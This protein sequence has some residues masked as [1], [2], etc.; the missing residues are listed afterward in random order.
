MLRWIIGLSLRLQFLVIV[1]AAVLIL[2]GIS[3]LREMPVDVYPEF[4]PP[5][6]E[7]QTEALG[8]SAVEMEALIT[9]PLEADLLNGVAWLDQ[10]YSESVAGLSSILLVFEPGTDPIKARQMVQERLTQTFALPNVSSPPTMLQPLSTTSRVMIVGLSSDE[11]SLLEMGVLARWN[12]KP[13]LTGVP[14]VANV[15]IWGHRDR[16]LQVLVDPQHL[17]ESGVSVQQVIETTGEALW[18]SPLSYLESSSPGTA[19]WIDTPNQRLSIRHELPISSAEELARVP[20][21]GTAWRLED[22]ATVVEDHQPLIGDAALGAEPGLLLVIE[23]FPGANTLEV[24]R[25]VEEA[26]DAMRP[27]LAGLEIDSTVFRSANY[28]EQAA[29]NLSVGLIA[30]MVLVVLVLFAFFYNW[31]TALISVVAVILP[32]IAAALVLYLRDAT[33]NMMILAG[34]VIALGVV[35][36]NA[37]VDVDNIVRRLRQHREREDDGTTASVVGEAAL[38]IRGPLMFALLIML[39]AIAPLFFLPGLGGS[40]LRPLAVS[41]VLALLT[42]LAVALLVTPALCLLFLRG[43]PLESR[44]SPIV[45]RLQDGYQRLL[46]RV[47]GIPR[48]AFILPVVFIG[49]ALATLPFLN[50]SLVP[51]FQQHDL[52]IE[53]EAASGTSRAEM[54]RV[55][56]RA[57]E[58]LRA[59]PG[60]RNVG[61]HVG[62]AITGD[63]VVGINSGQMW[64]SIDSS[65]DYDATL[66]AIR[67]V[68]NSFPGLVHELHTYQPERTVE[69]LSGREEDLVV[70]IYGHE[71][72]ILYDRANEVG[73]AVAGIDG[74]VSVDADSSEMEPQV[75]IEVDLAAAERYQIKP[76]DVRRQA[77]TLL[78][79][80]RVGNLYEENKVFDVVVW[81][82][83]EIRNS[84]TD[85]ENLLIAT[86]RGA[87]V[88]LGDLA[89]VRIAPTPVV[90]DRDAV[91]RFVDVAVTVEGR[92]PVA[93]ASDVR[94]ALLETTFPLEYHAEV[95]GAAEGDVAAQQRVV[96]V[97][98][99]AVIGAFL[100]MQASFGRWR[101]ASVMLLTLPMALSGGVFAG[102][103]SGGVL[104]LGSLFGFYTILGIAVRNGILLISRFQHLEQRE[105]Y[106]IGPDLVQQGMRERLSPILLTW[107]ATGLFFLPLVLVGDI[108]GYDLVRP[109][110]IVIL[111]GLFTS[112]LL[113]LVVV[114]TLY[115]RFGASASP[116]AV[117]QAEEGLAMGPAASD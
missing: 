38:E 46:A 61:S 51:S 84:L 110:A 24:T 117:V 26:L 44:R 69:A 101:L 98:V 48:L 70:R 78:S 30:A 43:V 57:T 60:I 86:P 97:A 93:V 6:V 76:G 3:Q 102:L 1:F 11:L 71:L 103:L 41:Y 116:E 4:D 66:A 42:S 105:G 19:G 79:G 18:V 35:V 17:R 63:T 85:I 56:T 113:N 53:W 49:L 108:P 15:A 8:L 52:L 89:D 91:S 50:L 20:V 9:V 107:L 10:I 22:I 7:V 114:P 72:D 16:Q 21:K 45:R 96:N 54:N 82:V 29:S 34:F 65:A 62:R 47:I 80:L 109:M 90:I 58:A 25:G 28:I 67:D 2:F 14:G 37:I 100:L 106:S 77:T 87:Y 73:Q 39:L 40:F 12:I 27:G 104:S 33:F 32:L 59:I 64:I 31:R 88:P 81:G 23:K 95:L 99:A 115:L 5:L 111:G 36:D 75:E 68:T 13:R 74:V 55:T 83:P 92:S 94:S 112:V